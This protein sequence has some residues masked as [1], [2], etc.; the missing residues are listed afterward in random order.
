MRQQETYNVKKIN[1]QT[2]VESSSVSIFLI[3]P[4]FNLIHTNSSFRDFARKYLNIN[5]FNKE[6]RILEAVPKPISTTWKKSF[7]EALKGKNSH[8]EITLSLANQYFFF[9]CIITP[10]FKTEKDIQFICVFIT[11]VSERRAAEREL[12]ET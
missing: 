11:D 10:I 3:D 5:S 2:I 12:K 1:I 6:I 7:N 4:Q 9:E 8:G